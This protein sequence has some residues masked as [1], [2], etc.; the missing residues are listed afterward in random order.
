MKANLQM[1]KHG[2]LCWRAGSSSS[3]CL[4]AFLYTLPPPPLPDLK[5]IHLFTIEQDVLQEKN[6]LYPCG[7]FKK[8]NTNVWN[9]LLATMSIQHDGKAMEECLATISS[10]GDEQE[11]MD[12]SVL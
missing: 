4:F 1:S 7:E 11:W 3:H 12:E 6:T 2:R 9:V 10:L 5:P 8:V